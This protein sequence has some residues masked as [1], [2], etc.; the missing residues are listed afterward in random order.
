MGP[1]PKHGGAAVKPGVSRL[2]SK[3][4][5]GRGF[6]SGTPTTHGHMHRHKGS[7]FDFEFLKSEM[8]IDNEVEKKEEEEEEE[9]GG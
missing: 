5:V 6:G 7:T 3:I 2:Y 4:L 1:E 8:C 9:E